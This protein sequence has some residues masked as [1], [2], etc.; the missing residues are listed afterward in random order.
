LTT[1]GWDGVD[2]SLQDAFTFGN[3][4]RLDL[5]SNIWDLSDF[6]GGQG[7]NGGLKGTDIFLGTDFATPNVEILGDLTV[8]FGNNNV[9]MR[10]QAFEVTVPEPGTLALLGLGLA[11]LGA[12]RRRQK[13]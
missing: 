5:Y 2:I 10:G 9:T 12:A 13:A 3:E 8:G 6:T 7:S 4:I 11:G 1:N